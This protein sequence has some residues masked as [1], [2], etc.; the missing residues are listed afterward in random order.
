MSENEGPQWKVENGGVVGEVVIVKGV[1][2][3]CFGARSH[4]KEYSE[5][6]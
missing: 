6:D 4:R 2:D 3:A 1:D 5:A